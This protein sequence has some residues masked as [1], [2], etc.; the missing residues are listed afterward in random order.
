MHI[1]FLTDNFPPEGNAPAN[2]TFEHAKEWVDKGHKVT[3]ITCAPNFPEGVVYSGYKNKFF[4][5]EKMHGIEVRRVITYITANS[6]F[7]KRTLDY[8][9]FMVSGFIA[10]L[11]V[12]RPDVVI[13]TSPQFF[14]ACAGW[15]LAFVK[16]KPFVFELRDLWPAS[17]IAVDA[18]KESFVIT[19]L[20][21]LELFLYKRA[22][23]IVS[24]THSFKT[25]LILR[26]ISEDKIKVVVN[27]VD[28]S[29]YYP[30]NKNSKF[31]L[32][33]NLAGKFV[34]GCIGT[35]GLAHA[36]ETIIHA[37]ERLKEEKELI[38]LFAGGGAA[39]DKLEELAGGKGLSNVV[40]LG[41]QD[42]REMS[43]VWSL[44]DISVVHLKNSEL[45]RHV[46]PSKIFESMAMGLPIVI[47]VP[48]GEAT[49]LVEA[50]NVGLKITPESSEQLGEA[51]LK[52][53]ADAE[54]YQ[55]YRNN[56]LVAAKKYERKHQAQL[57]LSELENLK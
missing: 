4:Q 27:G 13:A 15:M 37:A 10:G 7:I 18:M 12:K 31:S 29:I 45:F 42:K 21:K 32:K 33:H 36:L 6:G 44:C 25:D 17:I 5:K 3:V 55:L 26:G 41:R 52:L 54:L 11:F 28:S 35:Q 49:Q 2:R 47:G 20:E 9:S 14:C 46:I 1:L 22:G 56:G 23:L 50:D 57:M 38:F 8:L 39:S 51:I 30:R 34:V 48:E 43:E 19:L 40:F 16:W 53:K 24:V